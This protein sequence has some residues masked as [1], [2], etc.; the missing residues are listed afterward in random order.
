MNEAVQMFKFLQYD[1][2]CVRC[3]WRGLASNYLPTPKPLIIYINKITH[4]QRDPWWLVIQIIKQQ[5][6]TSKQIFWQT[7]SSTRTSWLKGGYIQI[8]VLKTSDFAEFMVRL[9]EQK[10]LFFFW[11]WETPVKTKRIWVNFQLSQAEFCWVL[12]SEILPCPKTKNTS[13]KWGFFLYVFSA[14][15]SVT[16]NV[17]ASQTSHVP[18]GSE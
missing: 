2:I 6:K 4:N 3:C 9:N 14:E 16:S 18:V 5:Q 7:Y 13:A 17:H 1:V 10:Y 12:F 15:E 11:R 8:K